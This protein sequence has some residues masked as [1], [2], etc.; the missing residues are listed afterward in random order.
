[1]QL[2]QAELRA[3]IGQGDRCALC[4]LVADA[5][6]SHMRSF[7][8]EHGSDP[9]VLDPI[10]A[11]WG[12]CA[13]HTWALALMEDSE[14]GGVLAMALL[15]DDLL[16][17][18][19]SFVAASESAPL[20]IPPAPGPG[21]ST[22][23]EMCRAMREEERYWVKHLIDRQTY[24]AS[25]LAELPRFCEPHLQVLTQACETRTHMHWTMGRDA[26]QSAVAASATANARCNFPSRCR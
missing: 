6:R 3:A 16:R 19:A 23:C 2:F 13:W 14:R 21:L 22:S 10:Y 7:L 20:P 25:D 26:P 5:D 11:A 17:H 4:R 1:M 12:L 9:M 8:R 24:P 18:L 15:A